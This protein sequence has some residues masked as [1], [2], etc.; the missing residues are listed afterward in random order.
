[1]SRIG[2][3]IDMM[4]GCTMVIRHSDTSLIS[5][6]FKFELCVWIAYQMMMPFPKARVCMEMWRASFG[7]NSTGGVTHT[8][9]SRARCISS[10]RDTLV[11]RAYLSEEGQACTN[12]SSFCWALC[13]N[14]QTELRTNQILQTESNIQTK[15]T[16]RIYRLNLQTDSKLKNL[17]HNSYKTI[18]MIKTIIDMNSLYLN[19]CNLA[20]EN[21]NCFSHWIFPPYLPTI[22][23]INENSHDEKL[24]LPPLTWWKIALAF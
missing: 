6:Q 14:L 15:T 7:E 22:W 19:A 2:G 11:R 10:C 13:L 20:C 16:D 8:C 3:M 17:W 23:L 1:M 12:A 5:V 9:C 24:H 21:Q 18:I 4:C